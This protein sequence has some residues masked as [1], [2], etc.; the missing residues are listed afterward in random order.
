MQACLKNT[1]HAPTPPHLSKY[2][3]SHFDIIIISPTI[4]PIPIISATS[5]VITTARIF[6]KRIILI[7]IIDIV[8]LIIVQ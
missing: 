3:D 2:L 4:I 8:N 6:P 1:C 7:M 5:I